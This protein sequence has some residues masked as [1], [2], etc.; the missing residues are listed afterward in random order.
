M[1]D[2]ISAKLRVCV[3]ELCRTSANCAIL[4]MSRSSG[5]HPIG[6]VSFG[7]T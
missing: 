4:V 3:V 6:G 1:V 5:K 2:V 7:W